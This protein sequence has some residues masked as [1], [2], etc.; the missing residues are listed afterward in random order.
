VT[1]AEID[2]IRARYP[3]EGARPLA[4]ELNQSVRNIRSTARRLGVRRLEDGT[5]TAPKR[6]AWTEE[7]DRI[8]RQQWPEVY[9][10]RRSAQQVADQLGVTLNQVRCRAARLGVSVIKTCERFW[11]E[12][13]DD[14]L[15]ENA[16]LGLHALQ[17]RFRRKGWPRTRAAIGNRLA[18][19]Q[20][21]TRGENVNHYSARGAAQLLGVSANTIMRWIRHGWL[22]AQPRT[23]GQTRFATP[24]EWLIQPGQL[25]RFIQ[26]HTAQVDLSCADKYW[27]V[28]LLTHHPAASRSST[29]D[30]A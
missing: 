7:E 21:R 4:R 13:E 30:A 14:Y 28:D 6:H 8:I 25:S 27:L 16:Y 18:R 1:P 10:K 24:V 2:L 20:L 3:T 12:E 19:L 26:E 17:K 15:Y 11:T 23:K 22:R 5:W 9:R 29:G